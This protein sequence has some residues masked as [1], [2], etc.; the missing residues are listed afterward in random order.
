MASDAQTLASP[1]PQVTCTMPGNA[2]GQRK[3]PGGAIRAM[4]SP[5]AKYISFLSEFKEWDSIGRS[6]ARKLPF[7]VPLAIFPAASHGYNRHDGDDHPKDNNC[8]THQ[9]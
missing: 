5:K 1:P 8:Q 3:C 2:C 7:V 9:D 6:R 4:T